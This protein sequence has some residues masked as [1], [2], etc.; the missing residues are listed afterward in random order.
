MRETWTR[1]VEAVRQFNRDHGKAT[2]VIV[3]LLVGFVVG[4]LF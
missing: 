2:A 3:A 1:V 4:K